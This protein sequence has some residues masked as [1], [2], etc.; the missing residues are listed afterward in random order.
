MSYSGKPAL[1]P[2]PLVRLILLLFL[3]SIF[4]SVV[5]ASAAEIKPK[6]MVLENGITLLILERPSL[7]IVSV[8]ALIRARDAARRAKNWAEADRIRED[9]LA[10][11][12]VIEDTASGTVAVRKQVE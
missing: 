11:G 10:Q 3:V 9:L 12:I 6:R 2:G 4:T 8:E 7:P 1:F 5:P